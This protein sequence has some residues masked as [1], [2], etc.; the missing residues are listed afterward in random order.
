[1][2]ASKPVF[3]VSYRHGIGREPAYDQQDIDAIWSEATA[4]GYLPCLKASEYLTHGQWHALKLD[5]IRPPVMTASL[6]DP[7]C[8]VTPQR[9]KCSSAVERQAVRQLNHWIAQLATAAFE[10]S[11][12][13]RVLFRTGIA[14]R[15]MR[16]SRAYVLPD[17]W[18]H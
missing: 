18:T 5:E 14:V 17:S 15:A 16:Q 2:A 8:D 12:L 10:D 7:P 6:A 13:G 9:L 1:M 3:V 4:L 11:F